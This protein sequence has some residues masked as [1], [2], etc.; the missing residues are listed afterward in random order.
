MNL[1]LPFIE[2]PVA[3][4]LLTVGVA[5]A[6]MLPP[7]IQSMT[8]FSGAIAAVSSAVAAAQGFLDYMA[9]PDR[10]ALKARHGMEPA[11]T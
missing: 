8:T 4:T 9:S 1:S 10:A 3:T 6:G 2:R 7:E 11:T 5:L